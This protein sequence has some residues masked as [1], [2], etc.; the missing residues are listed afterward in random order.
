[1]LVTE[2]QYVP[3]IYIALNL[4]L[5]EGTRHIDCYLIRESQSNETII[6]L[7]CP[8]NQSA[9]LLPNC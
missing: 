4:V 1:M 7:V 5:Y 9:Y 3:T 2:P 6:S 8:K